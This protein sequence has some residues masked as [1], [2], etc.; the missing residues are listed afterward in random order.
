[1]IIGFPFQLEGAMPS[2]PMETRRLPGNGPAL[3]RVGLGLAALGRPA[4][5][6]LGHDR[7]FP[8]GRS[9][10]AMEA[11][12]HRMFDR[13]LDAGIRYFDAARSYGRAEQ[14][15]RSWIDARALAPEAIV[16]GSKWGYRYT[17]DWQ[18]DGRVQE[19]KDH[20]IA[21]LQA[22][23]AESAAIL[24]PWLRLYQIH[25]ASKETGVLDDARVLGEMRR[26]RE[27]GLHLG[28]TTT[29]ARQIDTI[30]RAMDIRF[31]GV[32]LFSTIQSTWNVLEPSAGAALA[33]AHA[34]G[35]TVIVK[36]AL[37]N[38]RLTAKGSEGRSGPLADVAR[39]LGVTP[40]AVALAFVLAQPW[41]AVVLLGAT[42]EAQ[43]GA[44]LR[45]LEL[46]L[47]PDDLGAL[48]ALRS[49]ADAYWSHRARLPW[50]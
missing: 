4:Y 49:D 2:M 10:D 19:V 36:E 44:N 34:A 25:S 7:D 42:T 21:M 33:E 46:R 9:V 6:T 27:R 48:E 26:I 31:D 15:L 18:V 43:L 11:H 24:G 14:F 12:A 39:R 29:G 35:F 40:D 38:G 37:A 17:G 23:A 32:P 45:A 47:S 50:T 8:G 41:A 28:V 1:V 16:V 22:Q 20:G 3:T 13:A 5:M 30:R